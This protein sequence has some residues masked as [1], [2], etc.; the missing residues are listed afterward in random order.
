MSQPAFDQLVEPI[1]ARRKSDQI[2]DQ[3]KSLITKGLLGPGQVFP[4]ERDL[5]QAFGVSRSSVREAIR[6]LENLRLIERVGRRRVVVRNLTDELMP[7]ALVDLLV[8][9]PES[10]IPYYEARLNVERGVIELAA[11]R[12]TEEDLAAMGRALDRLTEDMQRFGAAVEAD[13]EFHRRLAGASHNPILSHL[14][15][16][17]LNTQ[18]RAMFKLPQVYSRRAIDQA[19]EEHRLIYLGIQNRDPAKAAAAL[20]RSLT[21]AM[22]VIGS[23]S[24]ND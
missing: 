2:V 10:L 15:T 19:V 17:L 13:M 4:A 9:Q 24:K 1:Q 5:S 8:D 11:E 7:P 22:E 18:Q 20:T 6:T 3:L 23:I 14:M 21:Y 12:R 16:S